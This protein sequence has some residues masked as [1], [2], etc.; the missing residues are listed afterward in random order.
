[1]NVSWFG[2]KPEKL[3]KLVLIKVSER[4][5][6]KLLDY[7]FGK[8]SVFVCIVVHLLAFWHKRKPTILVFD[9]LQKHLFFYWFTLFCLNNIFPAE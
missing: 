5:I 8:N 7:N 2:D 3:D 1:M 6:I 4:T 9:S